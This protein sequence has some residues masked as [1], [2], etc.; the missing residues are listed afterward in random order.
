MVFWGFS[1]VLILKCLATG[2]LG[3][4]VGQA[5]DFV[6]DYDPSEDPHIKPCV[7]LLTS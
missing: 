3:G 1:E 5:C 2:H 4:S 6:S 7:K